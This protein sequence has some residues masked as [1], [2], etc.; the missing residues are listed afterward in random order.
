MSKGEPGVGEV[1]EA[2]GAELEGLSMP[3]A[4]GRLEAE[5]PCGKAPLAAL[6]SGLQ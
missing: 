2:N 5:E 1:G 4:E 6:E 3:G